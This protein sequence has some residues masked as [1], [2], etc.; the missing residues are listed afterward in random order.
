MGISLREF[1]LK[2]YYNIF[3]NYNFNSMNLL[4]INPIL[5]ALL[6]GIFTWFMTALGSAMV[7]FFK[8][9]KKQ[10]LNTMLGLAAGIMVAASFWSLLNP[11]LEISEEQ[12]G[13]VWFFPALGLLCGGLILFIFDRILPH[14]HI[15]SKHVEGV[16]STLHRS[17]LLVFA[18]T[19]HNLPE[20]FA[21]GVAFGA[22]IAEPT[23]AVLNAAIILTIGMG[24]QNFPEGAAVSI[25][26]RRENYTRM[27]AFMMG[28]LSGLVEPI[29]AV[30]GAMLVLVINSVLPFILSLAAGAM[31]YVVSDELIPE[32]QMTE[33]GEASYATAGF[34]L[35]FAIMMILDVALG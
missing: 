22:L 21:V 26:L 5:L 13:I 27:K 18:I 1:S 24:I 3:N 23:Q 12:G 8:D 6:A 34:M 19:L 7:F 33:G 14:M 2:K 11:A 31:L 15:E 4:N 29:G 17:I 28:Q 9:I 16:R 10:V 32:S 25:P 30:L 20:G 35:G